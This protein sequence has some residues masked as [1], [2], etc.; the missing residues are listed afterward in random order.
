[1]RNSTQNPPATCALSRCRDRSVGHVI[2]DGEPLDG[3]NRTDVCAKHQAETERSGYTCH[4]V[5]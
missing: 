1:M 5:R 3:E 4:P 2:L